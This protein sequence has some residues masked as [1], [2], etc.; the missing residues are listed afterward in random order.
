MFSLPVFGS[1]KTHS[2]GMLL[3]VHCSQL[4]THPE[5]SLERWHDMF[6]KKGDGFTLKHAF[7]TILC[8]QSTTW[9][10]RFPWFSWCVGVRGFRSPLPNILTCVASP[11][12]TA[13]LHFMPFMVSLVS[14]SG[15]VPLRIPVLCF[16]L[17]W[18]PADLMVCLVPWLLC[19]FV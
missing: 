19:L 11:M 1:Y 14:A 15:G 7:K 18:F 12:F 3:Q 5:S 10:S 16:L 2:T 9:F 17:Q 6:W 13:C 4:E 8:V